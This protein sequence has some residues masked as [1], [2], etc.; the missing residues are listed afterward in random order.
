M[1]TGKYFYTYDTTYPDSLEYPGEWEYNKSYSEL[2]IVATVDDNVVIYNGY[3]EDTWYRADVN[4][5]GNVTEYETFDTMEDTNGTL[6][7][8]KGN[9]D[10]PGKCA[11]LMV[12][13]GKNTDPT[14]SQLEYIGQT[15]VGEDGSY[16]FTFKTKEEPTIETGDFII[17]L[18]IEGAEIPIYLDTIMSPKPT[19]IVEF[20]DEKDEKVIEQN[21][22][23]GN[24]A[25]L[26]DHIPE[27]EGYE[28]VGWDTGLSNVRDNLTV[29]P[30]FKEKEYTV[31]FINSDESILEMKKFK[32]KEQ[33]ASNTTPQQYGGKFIGWEDEDG[34]MVTEV[35]K[36]M[37]VKAIFDK[38][39]YV[40]TYMDWDGEILSQ[41]TVPFGDKASIPEISGSGDEDKI[42]DSWSNEGQLEFVDADLVLTPRAKFRDTVADP[43]INL[44]SGTYTK[45]QTVSIQC[46][47]PG[48]RIY[49]FKNNVG[50]LTSN[51]N[52]GL[53]ENAVVYTGPFIVEEN[54]D[55]VAV[56]VKEGMN[57][58]GYVVA[59]YII[60]T[61]QGT[62][63]KPVPNPPTDH[64]G[65]SGKKDNDLFGKGKKVKSAGGIYKSLGGGEAL[66]VAP[67]K[68]NASS[69]SIKAT[70]K[71]GTKSYKVTQISAKAF[72]NCKK[73][74]SVT[75]GKNVKQIGSQAFYGCK[76]L[77]KITI[78]SKTLKKVGNKAFKGIN[79]KAKIKVPKTKIKTYKKLL[80]GKGLST[81]VK[82]IK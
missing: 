2:E 68:K 32:Y 82:I 81:G 69:A 79:K 28:F 9:I 41:Q 57:N 31:V 27:K 56:A 34:K 6:R 5:K 45:S 33:L 49:Y 55:I 13:K 64:K 35:N 39:S 74:K 36:D 50:P 3:G 76:N 24:S 72:K 22:I 62:V 80:K 26:P 19:Y 44:K 7:T 11:T 17:T 48:A 46:T 60:G 77:K 42:F 4:D 15:M 53:E 70:I 78:T 38:A 20:L 52:G 16:Q 10:A 59:E 21:V 54:T 25:Q 47:T 66:Y 23:Q 67:I 12:Y 63:N 43:V 18:G 1:N 37:I 73:L 14:A 8:V 51:W 58:S 61:E 75:L 30:V 71:V 40:V 65:D 29:R